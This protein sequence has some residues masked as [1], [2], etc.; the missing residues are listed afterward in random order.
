MISNCPAWQIRRSQ[1]D[2]TWTLYHVS[3]AGLAM[4]K[5]DDGIQSRAA[6]SIVFLASFIREY[7]SGNYMPV[8]C[9]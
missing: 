6:V 9:V 5:V 3:L 1:P 4:D 8:G 2:G 7:Q